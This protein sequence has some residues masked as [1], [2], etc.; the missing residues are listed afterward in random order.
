MKTIT[1]NNFFSNPNDV[2]N[3][4]MSLDY[5]KRNNNEYFEGVRSLMIKKLNAN[6][7][8]SVCSKIFDEYY[9]KQ[10]KSF[11]A[12]LFFHKT[13]D[14]DKKDSQ[15]IDDKVHTDYGII[16]GIIY[17]TPEAPIDCG[18]QT[19]LKIDDKYI[20]DIKMGNVYNRLIVY[21]SNYYH[22]AMNLFGDENNNR[23]VIL[24]F[25]YEVNFDD[26]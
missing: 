14:N 17:L 20:P 3:F 11:S 12:D 8:N 1:L 16:A 10:P 26:I 23:L 6:L 19:Y 13:T 2:R 4:A 24:F 22:S 9:G 21:P 18:T 7:Y 5:R 15:W 25:L